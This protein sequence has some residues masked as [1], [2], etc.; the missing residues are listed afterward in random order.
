MP[1]QPKRRARKMPEIKEE[2][3]VFKS[4]SIKGKR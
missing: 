3:G 4:L 1:E 2:K